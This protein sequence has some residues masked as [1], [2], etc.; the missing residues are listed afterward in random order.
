MHKNGFILIALGFVIAAQAGSP[1]YLPTTGPVALWF[2]TTA[3]TRT[4][5]PISIISIPI[6]AEP[7]ETTREE[8]APEIPVVTRTNAVPS[9]GLMQDPPVSLPNY[10][11]MPSTNSF[12]TLIGPMM[13]TNGVVNP[14]LFMRFFTPANNGTTREALIVPPV[15]FNPARPPTQSSSAVYTK[16]QP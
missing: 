2:K 9:A 5:P 13:D 12:E 6:T 8:F 10:L 7:T 14:Q 16:S 4:P 3:P 1:G 15:G 11:V